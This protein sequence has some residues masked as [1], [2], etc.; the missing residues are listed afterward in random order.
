MEP[1]EPAGA[2]Q[3]MG[4][5]EDILGERGA[6]RPS[7][8]NRISEDGC[9]STVKHLQMGLNPHPQKDMKKGSLEDERD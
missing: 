6:Q 8:K 7:G 2:S 3:C 5:G 1:E 9:P 4:N